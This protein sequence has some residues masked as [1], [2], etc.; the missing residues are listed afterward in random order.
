[1]KIRLLMMV[2]ASILV[3]TAS[4]A[5]PDKTP[6]EMFQQGVVSFQNQRFE[7]AK[8]T[9]IDAL[10]KFNK[11]NGGISKNTAY[12]YLWLGSIDRKTGDFESALRYDMQA[13]NI[14]QGVSEEKNEI[15]AETYANLGS[16]Y[17]S[18]GD[19]QKAVENHNKALEINLKVH[20]DKPHYDVARDYNNLGVDYIGLGDFAKALENHKKALEIFLQ[21]YDRPHPAVAS[22]YNNLGE[23]YGYLGDFSTALQNHKK[24]LEID[25]EI[26]GVKPHA[27]V[28]VKYSNLGSDYFELGDFA[29]ALENHKNALGILLKVYGRKPHPHIA[30]CYNNIGQDYR[31]LGDF[32]SALQNHKKALAMDMKIYGNKPHPAVAKNYGNIG[33]DYRRLGDEK[34]C[35]GHL[36][37][38]VNLLTAEKL[39]P[40][41]ENPY[42]DP[43]TEN[44]LVK[45]FGATLLL[46]KGISLYN[47]SIGH[48]KNKETN[49]ELGHLKY[50]LRALKISVELIEKMRE[51]IN[52]EKYKIS[53]GGGRIGA[54]EYAIKVLL[55]L[56][57]LEKGR[58]W[59]RD[60]FKY[61][62]KSKSRALIELLDDAKAKKLAGV[63]DEILR[64]EKSVEMAIGALESGIAKEQ[65]EDKA[66][67][68]KKQL[69]RKQDEL[70]QMRLEIKLKYPQ[71]A[72]MKYPDACTVKDVQELL[73]TKTAL[74]EYFVGGD[75]FVCWVITNDDADIYR[76]DIKELTDKVGNYMEYTAHKH[77]MDAS[78]C[79]LGWELYG[80]LF[81]PFEEKL[82]GIENIIVIPDGILYRVPF[83]TLVCEI[84]NGTPRYL[85]EKYSMSYV[86]SA[87]VLRDI[88]RF[89]RKKT[90]S[91]KLFAMG[92]PVYN[93]VDLPEEQINFDKKKIRGIAVRSGE[94]KSNVYRT[95]LGKRGLVDLP[96]TEDEVKSLGKITKSKNY[97]FTKEK[98]TEGR[99]KEYSQK[100]LLKK[101]KY[102]HFAAHGLVVEDAPVLSCLAL[103]QDSDDKED[104]F[105]TVGEVFGL[106]LD[107]D[108]VT[109]S[110]CDLGL[111]KIEKG[112]GVMGLTRAF[113]Y[114]GSP[115]VAVSLWGVGDESTGMLMEKFYG[116]L[117]NGM[118]KAASLR[119]AQLD[120]MKKSFTEQG[121]KILCSAPMFWAPFVLYGDCR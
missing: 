51:G 77:K 79:V 7:E 83:Q 81:K 99:I 62:E 104:G 36:Q 57:E 54:Y 84:K 73:D 105:L 66:I 110:A 17:R 50:A 26:Y 12:C 118:D 89:A 92:N 58:G 115:A 108:L 65:S 119:Q 63:P 29:E 25:L 47:L 22:S 20:G 109:L 87:T 90:Y 120:L 48:R 103:A 98:A 101:F 45:D 23:D 44:I 112:E 1:M 71:Y 111:G 85:I 30:A 40:S 106:E 56:D 70:R 97:I 93:R 116:N 4:F 72:S 75:F 15:I 68:L 121:N 107:S 113:M 11:Q 49:N 95:I 86:Q 100:G 32:K 21:I 9:F 52:E 39:L 102:I 16:D 35:L 64:T 117:E 59:D 76:L 114:A 34:K 42:P 14:L 91:E 27:S 96:A 28:A 61:S 31:S 80:R 78:V 13:L 41:R 69:D 46:N 53:F 19:F 60:A 24:A 43:K 67:N 88:R 55:R 37:K 38:A 18:L 33:F 6:E 2:V 10:K 94:D 74:V 5:R 3:S 8:R 82:K